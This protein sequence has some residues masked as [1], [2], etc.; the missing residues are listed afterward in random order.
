MVPTL[1]RTRQSTLPACDIHCTTKCTYIGLQY[2]P[3]EERQRLGTLERALY[4]IRAEQ[5][6]RSTWDSLR[7]AAAG[8]R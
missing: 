8:Q 2:T 3:G 7:A 6:K 1:T 4:S 5:A